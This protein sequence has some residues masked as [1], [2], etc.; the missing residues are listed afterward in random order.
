MQEQSDIITRDDI[1]K[2]N[3]VRIYKAL[4]ENGHMTSQDISRMLDLSVPTV[5]KNLAALEED[6]LLHT[7]GVR[8]NTGGR[9]SRVFEIDPL[10]RVAIAV[11]ITSRHISGVA[12]D[13]SGRLICQVRYRQAYTRD[14]AYF[15]KLGRIVRELIVTG[16]IPDASVLGVGIVLPALLTKDGT[17]TYYNGVLRDEPVMEC[18]EFARYIPFPARFFHDTTSAA[19]AES[20][21]NHD[22]SD[23]FYMMLSDSVGAAVVL[24]NTPY[25]GMN[26][27]S[28]E[29]AHIKLVQDG[30]PCYCGGKGCLEAY[31]S[32]RVLNTITDGDLTQFFMLLDE[33]DPQAVELWKDY[34]HHLAY[35]IN[36]VRMLFDCSVVVGG[37]LGQYA[38]K[39]LPQIR[40]EVR[41]LD[42]FSQDT[43][44]LSFCKYKNE[45]AATGAALTYIDEFIQSI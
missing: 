35:G 22:I 42:P 1:K 11:S 31:C 33:G 41:K 34:V 7:P 45:A 12:V 27:R 43:D 29:F 13:L 37:Y 20:S 36:T 30:R 10:Q 32:T 3:R 44:F 18:A 40:R 28:G 17:R 19:Y 16:Q 21:I 9:S 5:N 23:F 39:Y 38:E 14:D 2:N 15:R 26:N 4:R 8:G 6:G 25:V 24:N